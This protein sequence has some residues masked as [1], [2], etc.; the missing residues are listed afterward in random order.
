MLRLAA[1]LLFIL[2]PLRA[3]MAETPISGDV[4]GKTFHSTGNPF[5]VEQDLIISSG[6]KA[7]IKEGC[8]FLFK[9]YTGLHVQ[10]NIYVE[11]SQE[12]PV[13]FTSINEDTFNLESKQLPNPFDWNGISISPESGTVLLSYF[14][15]RFSVYGIQS[16]LSDIMIRKGLFR[17]N[18]QF[19]FTINN[20]IQFVQDNIP[21][22]FPPEE[23]YNNKPDTTAIE[24]RKTVGKDGFFKCSAPYF[25]GSTGIV[26]GILSGYLFKLWHDGKGEYQNMPNIDTQNKM[27]R[28]GVLYSTGAISAGTMAA[29]AA[30]AGTVLLIRNRKHKEVSIAPLIFHKSTGMMI[31]FCW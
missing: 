7:V 19:H 15:L 26:C 10:G 16:Q 29:T 25:I 17:Q 14:E 20:R 13:V 8:I 11:G 9:P 23:I 28:R 31:A 18:G 24:Y 1:F 5:I 3:L 4:S 30:V 22:S 6:K 21:F 12:Q 2:I 27:D